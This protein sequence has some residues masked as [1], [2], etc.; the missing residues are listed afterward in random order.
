MK[1]IQITLL[2]AVMM[3]AASAARAETF[4]SVEAPLN[5]DNLK[6]FVLFDDDLYYGVRVAAERSAKLIHVDGETGATRAVAV[7]P[8]GRAPLNIRE[9]L[10][11]G[12]DIYFLSAP[13]LSYFGTLWKY[14]PS[15]DT[16]TRLR[17]FE[18][19]IPRELACAG[20][21]VFLSA[22]AT[23][24]A[25]SGLWRSDGTPDGTVEIATG[26][27]PENLTTLEPYVYFTSLGR[28][29]YRIGVTG[30]ARS[31]VSGIN[32]RDSVNRRT[33]R[34]FLRDFRIY[35]LASDSASKPLELWSTD[36]SARGTRQETFVATAPFPGKAGAG[37]DNKEVSAFRGN[38][39]TGFEPPFLG[40]IDGALVFSFE[41]YPF[42]YFYRHAPEGGSEAKAELITEQ[43]ISYLLPFDGRLVMAGP[44][45]VGRRDLFLYSGGTL[46]N[47]NQLNIFGKFP[48]PLL[49][50]GSSAYFVDI[51]ATASG[52]ITDRFEFPLLRLDTGRLTPERVEVGEELEGMLFAGVAAATEEK[53]FLGA[54]DLTGAR[55]PRVVIMRYADP[56][57]EGEPE[58][59]EEGEGAPEGDDEGSAEG[60]PVPLAEVAQSIY[61]QRRSA[62][63]NGDGLLS[64]EEIA[65]AG[66]SV[67]EEAFLQIDVNGDGGLS[68][69]ELLAAGAIAP[70][71]GCACVERMDESLDKLLGDLLVFGL[72]AMAMLLAGVWKMFGV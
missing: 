20:D 39:T 12:P 35:F 32:F 69:A 57:E 23:T 59:M 58:G 29:F 19:L 1:G 26:I 53:A 28:D 51:S 52:E 8:D 70:P 16:V 64:R 49:S 68:D 45:L 46:V 21:L 50:A 37:L 2:A 56:V 63:V 62:D 36:G 13:L 17:D 61:V 5:S 55:P 54:I 9:V 22:W 6:S 34:V 41:R 7:V 42:W 38:A 11:N 60:E 30:G 67:N 33:L 65:A 72:A 40:L 25:R 44:P 31:I 66:L 47:L 48:G 14:T 24:T 15:T 27:L 18:G 3:L 71:P 10:V 4:L 43:P